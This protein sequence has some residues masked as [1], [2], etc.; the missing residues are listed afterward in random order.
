MIF[1]LQC[2]QCAQCGKVLDS[3]DHYIVSEDKLLCSSHY[4]NQLLSLSNS[5][6][7]LAELITDQEG[8]IVVKTEQSNLNSS[9]NT[10]TIDNQPTG[11]QFAGN[12]ATSSNQPPFTPTSLSPPTSAALD[13]LTMSNAP[14]HPSSSPF[15][16][17]RSQ[18]PPISAVSS[19]LSNS[20]GMH[21]LDAHHPHHL[22]GTP[23]ADRLN[24][25][26]LSLIDYPSHHQSSI[27][28]LEFDQS[29]AAEFYSQPPSGYPA[30]PALS[31]HNPHL[32]GNLYDHEA[33]RFYGGPGCLPPAMSAL[34]PNSPLNEIEN[35]TH[36]TG[37]SNGL[38]LGSGARKGRPRKRK[39]I[40]LTSGN[41]TGMLNIAYL[42]T[43]SVYES[44]HLSKSFFLNSLSSREIFFF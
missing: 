18:Q 3:G 17:N 11:Q 41:N 22:H 5:K 31:A 7:S 2:F 33:M 26:S 24:P 19:S 8:E 44:R 34:T 35:H 1:H 15:L 40:G 16:L 12:A 36:G 42:F 21:T 20:S 43:F 10:S 25:Q 14:N 38:V 13:S 9:L 29:A 39:Q 32:L 23:D 37:P 30:N 27:G 4:P 28:K 6:N